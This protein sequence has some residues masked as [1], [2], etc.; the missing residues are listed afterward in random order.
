MFIAAMMTYVV[1]PFGPGVIVSDLNIGVLYIV[2]AGSLS[3]IAVLMAGWGSGNKWS[4]MGGFRSAAQLVSYEVPL[5]FALLG[6]VLMAG[7]LSMQGIVVWQERHVWLIVPQILGFLVFLTAGIAETNRPP[8]DLPEA[9]TELIA[10]FVTEYSGM[11]FAMF[12]LSEFSNM[13]ILAAVSVTLFLGGWSLPFGL[14]F[15]AALAVPGGVAVFFVKTYL[16]IWVIMWIR[17]TFPRL[18]VD[19]VT[20][21]TW[22]LLL[23]TAFL[24]LAIAGALV[25]AG[26]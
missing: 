16:L 25:A 5:V 3:V 26:M 13:F 22:K 8:F 7:T 23:P 17:W 4:L 14:R 19:Q 21:F 24:N 12:F 6:P 2:A 20:A 18:R 11:K 10:G 9:E 15:P 1:I